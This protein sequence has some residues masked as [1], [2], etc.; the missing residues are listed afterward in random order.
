MGA[1]S[2]CGFGVHNSTNIFILFTYFQVYKSLYLFCGWRQ[3]TK[4]TLQ[5]ATL[6]MVKILQTSS[7]VSVVR[8]QQLSGPPQLNPLAER[9][10]SLLS[11]SCNVLGWQWTS[12]VLIRREFWPVLQAWNKKD[13][14]QPVKE[15]TVV[16]ICKFIG[17]CRIYCVY[18]CTY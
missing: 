13:Q 18:V 1:G 15:V 5:Q 6:G 11:L 2:R 16:C 10:L 12:D 4:D 7:N 8:V 9:I 17:E 14:L 3:L